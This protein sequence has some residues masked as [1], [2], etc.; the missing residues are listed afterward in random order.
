M[1]KTVYCPIIDGQING[2]DCLE[3]VLV[4][5]REAKASILPKGIVWDEDQ[6][7]KCLSCKYHFDAE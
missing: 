6:R 2:I 4:A 5:D 1:E 7:S 3:I